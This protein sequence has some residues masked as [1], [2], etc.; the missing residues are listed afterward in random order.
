[1]DF[2]PDPVWFYTIAGLLSLGAIG[3]FLLLHSL[4]LTF[5]IAALAAV[6]C[7]CGAIGGEYETR[8][9]DKQLKKDAATLEQVK[10]ERDAARKQSADA[11][12]DVQACVST[13]NAQS[14]QVKAWQAE[15]ARRQ[16]DAAKARTDSAAASQAAKTAIA[17]YQE[18]AARPPVK[19]Q[20]CE[21]KLEAT[22]K[23]LRDAARARAAAKVVPK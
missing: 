8:G 10:A 21:Q 12:A 17:R 11:L 15:A 7:F 9:G 19:D 16:A 18:I 5:G 2:L 3:A 23:L 14:A 4:Q 1:M 6:L 22:D 20:T 13:T